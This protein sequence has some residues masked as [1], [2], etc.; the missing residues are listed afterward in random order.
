MAGVASDRLEQGVVIA[1]VEHLAL[2]LS[3]AQP[4]GR[5]VAVV[6]VDD[7]SRAGDE[8]RRPRS[9][10]LDEQVEVVGLHRA[11]ADRCAGLQSIERDT[12]TGAARRRRE[13]VECCHVRSAEVA[14]L[15]SV[16]SDAYCQTNS[17]S[18]DTRREQAGSRY[19]P[20]R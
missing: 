8:Q 13:L 11:E 9:A 6:A 18:V 7:P 1:A 5:L 17:L 14:P 19:G 3:Q 2:E 20:W 12:H 4:A 15:L 10:D 16:S